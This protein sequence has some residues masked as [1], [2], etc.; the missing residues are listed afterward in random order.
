MGRS[1]PPTGWTQVSVAGCG[2]GTVLGP[3]Q[4]PLHTG[5]H[6]PRVARENL[7]PKNPLCIE[8]PGFLHPRHGAGTALRPG[9]HGGRRLRR[10][11]CRPQAHSSSR[12]ADTACSPTRD[13]RS[14]REEEMTH[15][16]G[17]QLPSHTHSQAVTRSLHTQTLS[18]MLT[19][20]YT[21][22][23]TGRYT[24]R[25]TGRHTHEH[26]QIQTLSDVDT[27][28]YITHTHTGMHRH[29]GT[30]PGRHT[31]TQI[32]HTHTGR[33][34][35]HSQALSLRCRHTQIHSHTG[36]HRQT[37]GTLTLTQSHT[38]THGRSGCTHKPSHLLLHCSGH[39]RRGRPLSPGSSRG[40][41]VGK[42]LPRGRMSRDCFRCVGRTE[43]GCVCVR[44][45]GPWP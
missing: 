45:Q 39:P 4:L 37:Q 11:R 21:H 8:D 10:E 28:R 30:L 32:H 18:Q 29:T 20:R 33:H 23:F 14:H 7:T 9:L 15:L 44:V 1:L 2:E 38:H 36:M 3:Q 6:S 5:R 43:P 16:I 17:K 22:I 40:P 41:C 27:L 31:H 24:L 42:G 13:S 35:A 19:L 25:H 12:S 26:W 34:R